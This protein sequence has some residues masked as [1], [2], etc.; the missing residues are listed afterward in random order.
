[1][2]DIFTG[3]ALPGQLRTTPVSKGDCRDQHLR[4]SSNNDVHVL[5]KL[6]GTHAINRSL[7]HSKVPRP[8]T[9]TCCEVAIDP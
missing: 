2:D 9:K 4:D 8:A 6:I 3:H 1:M 7:Q 5:A